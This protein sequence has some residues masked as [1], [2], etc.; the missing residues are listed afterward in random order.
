MHE[1]PAT[2]GV[3]TLDPPASHIVGWAIAILYGLL[4]LGFL[5]AW[6]DARAAERR[7]T[8]ER[9]DEL[10]KGPAQLLG[11]IGGT[12]RIIGAPG[13]GNRSIEV[14]V[15][16]FT[17][18]T[19]LG[20]VR[21]AP[22]EPVRFDAGR[23]QER[24][25]KGGESV[26]VAGELGREKLAT[27]DGYRGEATEGWV[28]REPATAEGVRMW[29]FSRSSGPRTRRR[30]WKTGIL[31]TLLFGLFSALSLSGFLARA[32]L[33]ETVEATLVSIDQPTR[34][35][36]EAVIDLDHGDR[37][38]VT[39]PADEAARLEPGPIAYRTVP[40]LPFLGAVGPGAAIPGSALFFALIF[41]VCALAGSVAIVATHLE[42]R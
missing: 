34:H 29:R 10:R 24:P 14:P 33:G 27:V 22:K 42:G 8:T 25:L 13:D 35:G 3:N 28:L 16:P 40:A 6:L 26:E 7:A 39:F 23:L 30:S 12:G 19:D 1:L 5:F 41:L 38:T 15:E 18:E 36:A 31:A 2:Y 17:L 32:T 9:S 11:S 37:V 4:L 20:P 21:I